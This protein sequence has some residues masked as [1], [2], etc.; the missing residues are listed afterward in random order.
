MF[1]TNAREGAHAKGV[2]LNAYLL[3]DD[4]TSLAA[5]IMSSALRLANSIG[6][7]LYGLPQNRHQY[8]TE[9]QTHLNRINQQN[10]VYTHV[11]V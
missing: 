10:P 8:R 2:N 9:I 6:R 4:G 1:K 11:D 7:Q 5:R 3:G